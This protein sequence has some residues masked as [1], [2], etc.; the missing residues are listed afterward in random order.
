MKLLE[1]LKNSLSELIARIASKL[2]LIKKNRTKKETHE[3]TKHDDMFIG[4]F[5]GKYQY[6]DIS[7]YSDLYGTIL[8]PMLAYYYDSTIIPLIIPAQNSDK[9]VYYV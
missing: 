2:P 4:T 8:I 7:L 5:I 9:R 3:N 1:K 6:P